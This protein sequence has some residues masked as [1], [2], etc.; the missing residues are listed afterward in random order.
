M[1]YHRNGTNSSLSDPLVHHPTPLPP[2]NVFKKREIR[3]RFDRRQVTRIGSIIFKFVI[4]LLLMTYIVLFLQSSTIILRHD[5]TSIR[6]SLTIADTQ[7]KQTRRDPQLFL[8]QIQAKVRKKK[9]IYTLQSAKTNVSFAND[10]DYFII[11]DAT[12]FGQ[13]TGNLISG[14]LAAH[15]LGQE[16]DRIVCIN[17]QHY[18]SFLMAFESVDPIVIAKCPSIIYQSNNM[19]SGTE[20][21]IIAIISFGGTA[22]ECEIQNLM[23]DRTKKVI[24]LVGNTYP[25]WPPIPD[26]YFLY[27]Y[28]PT[29]VLYDILPYTTQ[30]EFVVH[31][32]EPDDFNSDPR[33]GLDDASLT[34]LGKILPK[35]EAYLVTNNV[36]YYDRFIKCCN[37]KN[38]NWDSIMHS[39]SGQYW[40][41]I[42]LVNSTQ[43]TQN[44]RMWSDW[45]TILMAGTVYHT[46]SDFSISAIH[47]MNNRNSYSIKGYNPSTKRLET[48][49]ESWWY[50]GE[51]IPINQ[52]T[53]DGA[54]NTTN[55]L[56]GC[57]DESLRL[58]AQREQQHQSAVK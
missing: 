1:Y 18:S 31:L 25:R 15:L 2:I 3:N 4:T 42:Q 6:N 12:L 13:G 47:W 46:H 36:D 32:R 38:S 41:N 21:H 8:Q 22:D 34:E 57:W 24:H 40:G 9:E 28:Q 16:F 37:W 35:A 54:P 49:V 48:T 39:A 17:P 44:L 43:E 45:Y 7:S 51:T 5:S 14:L 26:Y 58:T 20:Q 11:Y 29:Q 56:R 52:R 30:P 23:S 33:S 19:S 27:H 53:L 10:D 50:D 55:E